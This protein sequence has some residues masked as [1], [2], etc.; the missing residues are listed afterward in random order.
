MT[1]GQCILDTLSAHFEYSFPMVGYL[2]SLRI[3]IFKHLVCMVTYSY[4]F[5]RTDIKRVKDA[6]NVIIEQNDKV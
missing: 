5:K 2:G 3:I 4:E 6:F 1:C